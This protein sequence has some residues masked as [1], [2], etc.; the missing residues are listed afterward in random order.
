MQLVHRDP[1]GGAISGLIVGVATVAY[2][3]L[4]GATMKSFF[5]GAPDWIYDVNIGVIGLSLNIVTMLVVSALT[6]SM[7][8]S[9]SIAAGLG[10]KQNA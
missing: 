4:S 5:P 9:G 6:R 8:P 7:S 1:V 3:V 10:F 2:T